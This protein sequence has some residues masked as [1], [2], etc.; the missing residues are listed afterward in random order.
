MTENQPAE[1][2]GAND[3]TVHRVRR[4][5]ARL[6]LWGAGISFLVVVVVL[7]SLAYS[8]PL[9]IS[10]ETTYITGPLK[11]DGKQVDYFAAIREATRPANAATDENGFRLIVQHLGAPPDSEPAYFARMCEE[12]GLDAEALRP[13]MTYREPYDLL[14]DYAESEAFDEGLINKLL[15]EEWS[16]DNLPW[17]LGKKLGRPWTLD[18]LPMMAEWLEKNGPALDLLG[19]AVR[20]PTFHIPLVRQGEDDLV[21][22]IQWAHVPNGQHARSMARGLRTRAA[23]RIAV[24]DLDGASDDIIACKQLGRH[25]GRGLFL[26]DL[27][28]SIGIEG[29]ADVGIA[30]SLDHPPTQPQLQ[31][32]LDEAAD[33]LPKADFDRIMHFER[34]AALDH[35]QAFAHGKGKW[36][37]M[38]VPDD[39]PDIMGVHDGTSTQ[40]Y[41]SFGFDWNIVA[42]RFNAHYD[43]VLAT[44]EEPPSVASGPWFLISFVSPRARSRH[45]ADVFG[46]W[47]IP[48]PQAAREAA[49]RATCAR[50]VKRITLAMLL[51]ERDHGTLPPAWSVD[52]KGTPL[53]SWRVLLLPYLGQREL[54]ERIRLD[55][56]WDSEYNRQFHGEAVPFY[57]CPSDP[58]ARPGETTYSVVIGPDMPFEA[59]R[60]KRLADFGPHSD[61]MILLVERAEPVRWMDPTHEVR[62]SVAEEGIQ[63][64]SSLLSEPPPK[65][66]GIASH[67]P[68]VAHFGLRKGA[69]YAFPDYI[70]REQFQRLLNGTNADKSIGY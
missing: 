8:R 53:H 5:C 54:H 64:R 4:G 51:Y 9:R 50:Y 44:G 22:D 26:L 34:L 48:V 18:D 63:N 66:N 41:S 70:D 31:R 37:T 57:R 68:G 1:E 6:C 2:Q 59:G 58:A 46:R 17:R 39:F 32:L 52:A 25:I 24:G 38:N 35:V 19:R 36:K 40:W 27:L 45:L 12:L 15:G 16:M 28:L 3:S 13:D 42:R 56:P 14:K 30:G 49:R 67:H 61:D 69:V 43:R 7:V 10:E 29:T 33:P 60:G 23:Y 65:P 62:Q 11:S 20:K 55:E 47:F 21:I